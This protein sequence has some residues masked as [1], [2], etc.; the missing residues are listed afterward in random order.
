MYTCMLNDMGGV[1]DD[2]MVYPSVGAPDCQRV[3]LNAATAE[4]DLAWI[5]GITERRAFGVTVKPRRDLAV[6]AVQGPSAVQA[7][8][9]ALP[10]VEAAA[11][12]LS[13]FRFATS[14]ALLVARTGYTGEDGFEVILPA[15]DAPD[16]WTRLVASGA[17]PC[18]LGARDTLR[19][20]AGLSLY[21]QDLESTISPLESG[22]AW[23]V[24]LRSAR[25]FIGREALERQRAAGGLRQMLG[26]VLLEP[27]VMRA[28]QTVRTPFGDGLV[29]S[30]T[31]SPTLETS[32][33]LARLPAGV[34]A[35]DR[36]EV[37]LR[38]RYAPVRVVHPRFVRQ[39]KILVS[40]EV[41]GHSKN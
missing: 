12:A 31:F 38:G 18:G 29:T 6:I 28:H 15:D 13:S 19:L 14:G 2:L 37:A 11:G 17:V 1:V 20:E 22:L 3:V 30:G 5:G 9:S 32:I 27:G 10:S 36:A 24:D 8:A 7:I 41:D 4:A 26:L 35:G 16:L 33:G 21:G 39:G 40:A 34:T 23:T 25:E